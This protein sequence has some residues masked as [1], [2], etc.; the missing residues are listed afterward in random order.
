LPAGTRLEFW[1]ELRDGRRLHVWDI[2]DLWWHP[3][4]TWPTDRPVSIDVPD[5]PIR[6]FRS[7]SARLSTQD[8][9]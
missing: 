4:S 9:V 1:L 7:W 2:A 3:P 6:L 8:E 5:V